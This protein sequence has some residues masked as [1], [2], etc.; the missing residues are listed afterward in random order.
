MEQTAAT[1]ANT[2]ALLLNGTSSNT[3][4]MTTKT[5]TVTVKGAVFAILSAITKSVKLTVSP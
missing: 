2:K 1:N 4:V 3:F 5:T